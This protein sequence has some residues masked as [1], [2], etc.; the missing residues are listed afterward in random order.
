VTMRW[1]NILI[2]AFAVFAASSVAAQ[3]ITIPNL[4]ASRP[5]FGNVAAAA[6]GDTVFSIST[7]SAV[8]KISGNGANIASGTKQTLTFNV[9]CGSG[10]TATCTAAVGNVKIQ[11]NGVNNARAG[12]VASFDV[13]GGTANI[14]NK[15]TNGDGSLEFQVDNWTANN[16]NR[17]V[18]LKLNLPVKGDDVSVLTTA[19][20][21]FTIS[22]AL[23]PGVPNGPKIGTANAVVRRSISATVNANLAYGAVRA[24]NS[25]S[26]SV[27]INQTTGART[28]G[29]G[30]PPP[31]IAGMTSGRALVTFTGEPSTAFTITVPS[32]VT[33]TSGAN[34]LSSTL[35][36]TASGAQTLSAGG[37]LQIG[38]G[39]AL[40]VASTSPT[41]DY[42]G[43][44]NVTGAYN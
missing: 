28:N 19:T 16:Q 14:I 25:G 23:A 43:S 33:L 37:T 32:T 9:R 26:G 38:I 36:A 40:T 7:A 34:N 39:G 12:N 6:T 21:Q 5:I 15:V 17:T 20:S 35:V 3:V 27:I 42:T 30:S 29:G 11:A 31:L 24:P 18:L 41:G 13:A 1:R 8:T 22:A 44:F 2:G 10:T 4:T